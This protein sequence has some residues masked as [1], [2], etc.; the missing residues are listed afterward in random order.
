MNSTLFMYPILRQNKIILQIKW[1]KLLK[2]H[3][4]F[5]NTYYYYNIIIFN[6]KHFKNI[7]KYV[8]YN[9]LI[10]MKN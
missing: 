7:N 5:G 6:L 2:P 10:N 8:F 1:F 9:K 3:D 4:S